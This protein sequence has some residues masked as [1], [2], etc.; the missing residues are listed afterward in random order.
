MPDILISEQNAAAPALSATSDTPVIVP[1]AP[2]PPAPIPP[3]PEPAAPA[4]PEEEPG[5][6]G[7]PEAPEGEPLQI[8][9]HR[10]SARERARHEGRID[11]DTR[12]VCADQ[13]E[14]GFCTRQ[15]H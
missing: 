8:G 12:T 2:E 1:L 9:L 7:P 15:Q 5:Q 11:L 14:I 4:E 10:R 13:Q 3:G 6:E